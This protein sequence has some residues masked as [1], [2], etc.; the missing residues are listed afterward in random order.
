MGAASDLL[1]AVRG[2]NLEL[3]KAL[4]EQEPALAR[5]QGGEALLVAAERGDADLAELLLSHG[6]EIEYVDSEQQDTPLGWA[7]FYGKRNVAEVLL[8]RG[9]DRNHR[10]SDGFTPLGYALAGAR[11]DLKKWGAFAPPEDYLAVVELLRAHG[12]V[13]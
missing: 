13:E 2:S 5:A 10:D 12:A 6:A 9:A 4:V 8:A 3:V 7:A 1:E 11:G